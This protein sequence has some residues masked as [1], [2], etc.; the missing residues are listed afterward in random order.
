MAIEVRQRKKS[1]LGILLVIILILVIA[2]WLVWSFLKPIEILQ[3]PKI[4]DLLPGSTQELISAEL[5]VNQVFNHPVFQTLTSH[6]VWPLEIP[7][8][9]RKNPFEP[10]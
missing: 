1:N 9:G 2:G 3:K 4:E 10:F 6:I 5:N 7:Q 8:L